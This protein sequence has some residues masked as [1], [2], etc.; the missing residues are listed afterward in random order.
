MG[1][2]GSHTCKFGYGGEDQPKHVFRSAGMEVEEQEQTDPANSASQRRW[3]VG[4]QALS[5]PPGAGNKGGKAL[6]SPISVEA[7]SGV[8]DWDLMES[9]W[10][11]AFDRLNADSKERP[12]LYAEPPLPM[13][14]DQRQKLLE[15]MFEKM[16][17]PAMYIAAA[18]ML[19]A[20]SAGR[21]TALI[22]ECSHSGCTVTPVVE[23][24]VLQRGVQRSARGGEWLMNRA[25]SVIEQS[26]GKPVVARY[27][28]K[29]PP[30]TV[31]P[32]YT[33]YWRQD[34]AVD[35][36]AHCGTVEGGTALYDMTYELPDGTEVKVGREMRLMP[37]TLFEDAASAYP[38]MQK[39]CHSSLAGS[40]GDVRKEMAGSVVLCGGASMVPGMPEKLSAELSTILPTSFK[41]K[42]V[43]GGAVERRY[44]AWIG[45]SILSCLGTFQQMWVS[46]AQYDEHGAARIDPNKMDEFFG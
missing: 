34:V 19:S 15:L 37:T 35:F 31:H 32:S 4:D 28:A 2:V 39:L 30:L 13:R 9:L 40:D 33:A 46:R 16:E 41:V 3:R 27:A 29:R 12:V 5:L 45:G 42:V 44:A 36:I 25:L 24:H 6:L 11:H 26:C 17:V 20:F 22:C 18:G 23:G 38:S 43:A 1:D 7:S 8:S 21:Q 14:A 10:L